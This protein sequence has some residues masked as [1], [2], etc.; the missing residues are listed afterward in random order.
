MQK[1]SIAILL[2]LSIL[3]QGLNLHLSDI[4]ELQALVQ[5]FEEHRSS[6]GDDFLTFFDKHY[7][8]LR[9]EHDDEEHKGSDQHE[10]LPFKQKVCQSSTG[11]LINSF[12]NAS[13]NLDM[14]PMGSSPNYHYLNNYSFL[15]N[16]DI[17]QPP[18]LV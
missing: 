4:I 8:D 13:R 11:V 5:H 2:S 7:G 15:D 16:S 10:K 18:R 12:G 17:F 1:S 14:S 9:Q 3:F 6:F